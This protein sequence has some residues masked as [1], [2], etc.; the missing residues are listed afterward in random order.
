MLISTFFF[1]CTY[2][3]L[4]FFVEGV[5]SLIVN[6]FFF[7][8][9]SNIYWNVR[10]NL[11]FITLNDKKL[12]R[13]VGIIS[14]ISEITAGIISAFILDNFSIVPLVIASSILMLI[15]LISF[16]LMDEKR[17]TKLKD[18]LI[19]YFK[20]VPKT[21]LFHL[22]L[23][24]AS[25]VM[26]AFFPLYLYIYVSNTYSFA[27]LANFFLGLASI[28]FTHFL[29]K[30]IDDKRESYLLLCTVLICLIYLSNSKV[31]LK[32]RKDV[33]TNISST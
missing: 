20:I 31:I 15:S 17:K 9:Y 21:T 23:R 33:L 18:S 11:E 19:K 5:G 7:A 6:V 16:F 8:L 22:A 10:H 29:S 24:E 30:R 14:Q 12:G 3:D 26:T 27:G 1:I 28:I 32:N 13:K 4:I 2:V 25:T